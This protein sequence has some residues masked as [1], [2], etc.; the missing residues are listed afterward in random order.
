MSISTGAAT[1]AVLY[2]CTVSTPA[3]LG[4]V[5]GDVGEMSHHV[6]GKEGKG[7]RGFANP[8]ESWRRTLLFCFFF[9]GW[10]LQGF[11]WESS[12]LVC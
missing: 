11:Y 10:F 5:P 3:Y 12:W 8:W 4:N 6:G 9:N 1:A 7:L 2:A